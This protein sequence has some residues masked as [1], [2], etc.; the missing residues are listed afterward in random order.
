MSQKDLGTNR[1]DPLTLK[2]LRA[3]PERVASAF[4]RGVP[5]LFLFLTF[6]LFHHPAGP[7]QHSAFLR[8][9]PGFAYKIHDR[10]RDFTTA[11]PR[12]AR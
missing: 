7:W 3:Y 12:D 6:K 11:C 9:L 1:L 5:P 4:P 2:S 10:I 8:S